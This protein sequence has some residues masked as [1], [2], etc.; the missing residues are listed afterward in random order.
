MSAQVCFLPGVM[1]CY[2]FPIGSEANI[3]LNA[4]TGF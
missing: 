4:V 3:P 2:K 1:E